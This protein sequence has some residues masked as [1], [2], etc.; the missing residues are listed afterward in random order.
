MPLIATFAAPVSCGINA[1]MLCTFRSAAAAGTCLVRKDLRGHDG[2]PQDN[3]MGP[4]RS[5]KLPHSRNVCVS[6]ALTTSGSV[7]IRDENGNCFRQNLCRGA[8]I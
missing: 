8:G 5:E 7:Q 4:S 2:R 6:K 3:L 1:G